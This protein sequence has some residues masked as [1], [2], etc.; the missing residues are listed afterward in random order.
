MVFFRIFI[1]K[2]ID[3]LLRKNRRKCGDYNASDIICILEAGIAKEGLRIDNLLLA[4][5]DVNKENKKGCE[6]AVYFYCD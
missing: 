2:L 1:A 3:I 4:F 6:S 5:C